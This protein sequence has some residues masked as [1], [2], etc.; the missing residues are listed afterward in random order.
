MKLCFFFLDP[1]SHL[2]SSPSFAFLHG[3]MEL[4]N[5]VGLWAKGVYLLLTL[6]LCWLSWDHGLK[7]GFYFGMGCFAKRLRSE[8]LRKDLELEKGESLS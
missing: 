8:C 5:C 2:A 6:P 4:V 3:E 1:T 7:V